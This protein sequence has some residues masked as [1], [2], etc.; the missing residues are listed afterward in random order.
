M[1]RVICLGACGGVTGSNYLVET[2]RGTR[3]LVDCGLFQGG[4]QAERQNWEPWGFDPKEIGTMFL[5]HAHIDHCGRVPKLAADGF[6]GRILATPPT[7]ELCNI[8]L[9]DSAGI[10][11]MNAEWQNRKN[12]RKGGRE[13]QPLY[14]VGQ[15]QSS[16]NLFSPVERDQIQEAEPG[17]KYRFRNAGHILGSS[18]LELWI[19]DGE[20]SEV[21]IVFSGDLGKKDQLIVREP[22]QVFEADY[23]FCESTYGNRLHR[24]FEESKTEFLEAILHAYENGEKVMIPAFAVERTQEIIYVLGEFH[25]AGKLPDMPI[26]LDSP[27]AIK[28]TEIFRKHKKYYDED[29]KDILAR[30]H[31]PLD[32][33]NLRF[34][35]KTEDSI[36]INEKRGPAIVIAGNGMCTAGR[37]KHHLKH[38]LWRPGASLVI[39]GFQAQGTT[40]RRIVDGADKV[41]I[42]RE[43]VA[44]R[45]K[46]F[47]IGGFSAHGDQ[48]DLLSWV[49]H[50]AESRP[51]IF[52]VH[53]E[54]TA[55]QAFAGK[56]VDRF[57]LDVHVPRL[58]ES[59]LLKAREAVV[60]AEGVE[61]VEA[62]T[63]DTMH[64]LVVEME[65][66][67]R[68][69]KRQIP[70]RFAEIKDGD[71]DLERLQFIA[72]ELAEIARE[73]P[74][75]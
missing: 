46:V 44:V 62:P 70:K 41:K 58:K 12:R 5:T 4:K 65:R 63:T 27:L 71:H 14:T 50:F 24:T 53:G 33:E 22:H 8:L 51:R 49:G 23:V 39:V 32:L 7:V 60:E 47:T 16:L 75:P 52:L 18:I 29:S 1:I 30:G 19:D 64:N 34:T 66:M 40:G 17:V 59:L 25:R 45:A 11:E 20:G 55:K 68:D 21:K 67:L 31:D 56:I 26:Y 13:I 3:L 69:I 74:A 37:I 2:S 9:L 48:D 42:F 35:P 61:L 54:T 28:A 57:G 73:K 36:A 72:E 43:D 15:A 6:S 38:N 10:Q